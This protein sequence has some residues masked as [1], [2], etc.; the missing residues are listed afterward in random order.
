MLCCRQ[1]LEPAIES[2]APSVW[3][4]SRKRREPPPV[5]VLGNTVSIPGRSLKNG[6]VADLDQGPFG[7]Y[8]AMS[9]QHM[10]GIR[11]TGTP[12]AQHE[13]QEFVR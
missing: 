5:L 7:S 12:Y 6:T 8:G 10:E 1:R 11:Y 9:F 13:R 2:G 3:M 4:F